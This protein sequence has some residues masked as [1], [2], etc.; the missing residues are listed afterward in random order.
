MPKDPMTMHKWV[1]AI[2]FFKRKDQVDKG[3]QALWPQSSVVRTHLPLNLNA[4]RTR[5]HFLVHHSYAT[6]RETKWPIFWNLTILCH[7]VNSNVILT[8]YHTLPHTICTSK[9]QSD[10]SSI[11]KN[12]QETTS[13]QTFSNAIY[14][15]WSKDTLLNRNC[16]QSIQHDTSSRFPTNRSQPIQHGMENSLNLLNFS[17][18]I[19]SC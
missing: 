2:S 11:I 15:E 12:Y 16:T 3:I 14:L 6:S 10:Q 17:C 4:T 7:A 5:L 8:T 9:H 13:Q 19:P 1:N 18:V